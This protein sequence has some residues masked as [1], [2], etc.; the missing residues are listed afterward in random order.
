MNG[1]NT[2]PPGENARIKADATSHAA[3]H[4]AARTLTP[5]KF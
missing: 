5:H 2:S 3:K 4:K 1:H